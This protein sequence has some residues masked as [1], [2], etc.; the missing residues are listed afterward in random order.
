MDAKQTLAEINRVLKSGNSIPMARLDEWLAS[1]DLEVLGA[2]HEI[3]TERF[4]R[5]DAKAKTRYGVPS[6]NVCSRMLLFFRR[7][8]RENRPGEFALNRYQAGRCVYNWFLVLS[9][10]EP[11]PRETLDEIKNMQ[12]ELY[13]SGDAELRN[14]IVTSCLEHL[15]ESRRIAEYF[16][17]W[18]DDPVLATA[19]KEAL[20]WGRAFW[21]GQR[22]Y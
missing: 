12:A 18:Q 10:I 5:L 13:K 19:F 20:E 8:L 2:C 1:D 16:A 3:L 4:D 17:D 14:C 6:E 9:A 15:F 11:V 7:C 21:P 22:G